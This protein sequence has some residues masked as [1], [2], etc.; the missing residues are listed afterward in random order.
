MA[1][2]QV[3]NLL[4]RGKEDLDSTVTVSVIFYFT[5]AFKIT[6]PDRKGHIENVIA[7]ANIAFLKSEIPLKLSMKC[8]LET[9]L[10]EAPDST[11]RIR[12]FRES[13]GKEST[14]MYLKAV[15]F[16]ISIYFHPW[17]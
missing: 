8:M 14:M 17:K 6:T 11:D 10:S 15:I 5:E 3:Q 16:I 4:Q 7:Q 12:E 2:L 9:D 13:Q 1:Y